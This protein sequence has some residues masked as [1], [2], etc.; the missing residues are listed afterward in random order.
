MST[1]DAMY[2]VYFAAAMIIVAMILTNIRE[3]S[4]L[5][6]DPGTHLFHATCNFRFPFLLRLKMLNKLGEHFFLSSFPH[7]MF[8][9]PY[10]FS[11]RSPFT[12]NSAVILQS[13]LRQLSTIPAIAVFVSS[14]THQSIHHASIHIS[15]LFPMYSQTISNFPFFLL[16]LAARRLSPNNVRQLATTTHYFAVVCMFFFTSR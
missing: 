8:S 12:S 5:L 13:F 14:A 2:V 16:P 4:D 11:T 9:V 7:P 3:A 10:L 15:N 6:C 1:W